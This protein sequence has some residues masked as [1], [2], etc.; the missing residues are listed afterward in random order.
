MAATEQ[1]RSKS[2]VQLS[3][4]GSEGQIRIENREDDDKDRSAYAILMP[5]RAS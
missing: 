5:L 2:E 1:T 4:R 3:L